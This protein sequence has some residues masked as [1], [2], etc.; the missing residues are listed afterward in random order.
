MNWKVMAS[1]MCFSFSLF[2]Q[3]LSYPW[4]HFGGIIF[5][6][7]FTT[8][9][10]WVTFVPDIFKIVFVFF[11]KQ[12]YSQRLSDP[13]YFEALVQTRMD[14]IWANWITLLKFSERRRVCGF[15]QCLPGNFTTLVWFINHFIMSPC[16]CG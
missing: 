16:S 8:D 13:L 9:P 2:P 14:L 15:F 3:C 6:W 5:T 12:S 10:H 7:L 4:Y 11:L 1:S